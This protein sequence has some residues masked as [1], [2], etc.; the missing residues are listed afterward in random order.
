MRRLPPALLCAALLVLPSGRAGSVLAQTKQTETVASR[1]EHDHQDVPCPDSPIPGKRPANTD[2][3]V[4]A[5]RQFLSLPSGPMVLRIDTFPTR[6]SA[7]PAATPS[8]IVVEAAGK[9]WLLT[10]GSKGERS[11]GGKFV[12]ELGPLPIPSAATYEMDVS[13]ADL[14]SEMN[15]LPLQHV[16]PG[17]EV[18][19][20]L[21]GEHK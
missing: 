17:P 12:T 5:R 11:K 15:S 7:E 3:A 8:S 2:C 14:G 1:W 4:L 20:L 13:E 16:H 9:V 18:W 6:E 21:T 19:Y 10:L